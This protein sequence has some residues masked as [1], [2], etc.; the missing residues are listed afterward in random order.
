[1]NELRHLKDFSQVDVLGVRSTSVN[2]AEHIRLLWGTHPSTG[3]NR[4]R[5]G[6]V[7]KAHR[8]LYHSILGSRVIKKKTNPHVYRGRSPATTLAHTLLQGFG[9]RV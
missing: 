4:F 9:F 7:F 6:L 2:F 5:G 8:W 1:M 3:A